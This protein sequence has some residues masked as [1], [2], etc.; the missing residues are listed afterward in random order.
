MGMILTG[1]VVSIAIAFG[2]G[3]FLL[4]AQQQQPAWQ[5]YS[6]ESTRVGDPGHNLVGQNWTGDNSTAVA[7]GEETPS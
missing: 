6:S 2:A 4:N 1:I 5:V 7:G 3:Y